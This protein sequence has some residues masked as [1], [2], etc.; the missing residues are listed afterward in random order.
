MLIWYRPG[1]CD[2]RV[3]WITPG[4][5]PSQ[6]WVQSACLRSSGSRRVGNGLVRRGRLSPTQTTMPPEPAY[7]S[8]AS[9]GKSTGLFSYATVEA[10][11]DACA[12]AEFGV[13][14]LCPTCQPGLLA[15]RG[16]ASGALHGVT[17]TDASARFVSASRA[18]VECT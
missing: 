17:R 1:T 10:H 14:P 12:C 7:A 13:G 5:A 6:E 9:G 15:N 18:A 2:P 8:V 3:H 11:A 4:M 16:G